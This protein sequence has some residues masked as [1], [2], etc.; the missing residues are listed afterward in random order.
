[1]RVGRPRRLE[2]ATRWSRRGEPPDGGALRAVEVRHRKPSTCFRLLPRVFLLTPRRVSVP[3]HF[4]EGDQMPL[5]RSL[6]ARR[7]GVAVTALL[8]VAGA[9]APAQAMQTAKESI[10]C[11]D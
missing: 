7:L 4:P 9:T 8:F 11:I 1:M 2:T 5:N 10:H 3:L 6:V